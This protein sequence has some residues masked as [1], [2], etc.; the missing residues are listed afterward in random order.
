MKQRVGEQDCYFLVCICSQ[1]NPEI[2]FSSGQV[3]NLIVGCIS[4]IA[5]VN[6][7]SFGS[8]NLKLSEYNTFK[9]GIIRG[10]T[11]MG[12][13]VCLWLC[14]H[15]MWNALDIG[16]RWCSLPTQLLLINCSIYAGKVMSLY[17]NEA[18]FLILTGYLISFMIPSQVISTTQKQQ[19]WP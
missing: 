7:T 18:A 4:R 8:L 11:F 13:N 3:Q 19:S 15:W 12:V 16:S 14:C 9:D 2:W 17:Q 5:R 10:T 1:K 6:F